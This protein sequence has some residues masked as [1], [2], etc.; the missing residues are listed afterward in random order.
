[1]QC[2]KC[3][4]EIDYKENK[5]LEGIFLGFFLGLIGLIIGLCLYEKNSH[6]KDTFLE[7]WTLTFFITLSNSG[8][9]FLI[10]AIIYHI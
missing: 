3:G 6:S 10:I 4:K 7:A 1:M 2:P 9:I 5:S 8:I